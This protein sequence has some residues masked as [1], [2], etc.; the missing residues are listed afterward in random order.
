M[1][2]PYVRR[3]RLASQ[4]RALREEREMTTD[5]LA[6]RIH[7]SRMKVSRLEN[8][9]GRP[10]V[11][12]VIRILDTFGITGTEWERIVRLANSAAQKGWWDSHGESIGTRQRLY[13]DIESGAATIREYNQAALPG[14]LQTLDFIGALIEL[15]KAEGP[16]SYSPSK[17][18]DARLRR[19]KDLL[20][21]DGPTYEVVVDEVVIRRLAVPPEIMKSQLLHMLTLVDSEPRLTLRILPLRTQMVGTLLPRSTFTL[22]T[23]PDAEDPPMAAVDITTSDLIYTEPDDVKRYT[24]KYEKIC[25]A[26]LSPEDSRELLMK[27]AHE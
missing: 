12:D 19:G 27:A 18:T 8:A 22:Y 25:R 21:P 1:F 9:S 15:A 23:F 26:A 16:L 17:M 20:R 3:R 7:Y 11:S 13:I 2:S 4:L 24:R 6:K 5:E 10:D 14:A